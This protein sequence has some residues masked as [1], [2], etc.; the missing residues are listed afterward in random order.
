[1]FWSRSTSDSL[2]TSDAEAGL[3][4]SPRSHSYTRRSRSRSRRRQSRPQTPTAIDMADDEPMARPLPMP[5]T[6]PSPGGAASSSGSKSRKKPKKSARI[7]EEPRPTLRVHWARFK[8]HMGTGTAPSTSSAIGGDESTTA[9]ESAWFRA[10]GGVAFDDE[11]GE[12]DEVVVDR[13]WL[14]EMKSTVVSPSEFPD[15]P[16]KSSH[17]PATTT[18]HDSQTFR[19]TGAVLLPYMVLRYR[20]WPLV[21]DFFH[22]KFF[23]EKSEMHYRKENWFM[24]KVRPADM[25][26]VEGV[27]HFGSLWQSGVPYFS[28]STGWAMGVLCLLFCA[29][30]SFQVLATAFAPRPLPLADKIFFYAVSPLFTFPVF[31]MVSARMSIVGRAAC[32]LLVQVIYNWPRDRPNAYQLFLSCS[33]WQWPFYNILFMFLCGF[34]PGQHS[35]F[36]CG[37]KDFIGIF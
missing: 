1:M 28:L 35:H 23:D 16:D 6:T 30:I 10:R 2:D 3:P 11:Q 4:N 27:S 33:V 13:E 29:Q 21:L 24:K 22:L 25:L 32:S 34:Y 15:G 20:I 12:L 18:D 8:R 31:F 14:H 17:H 37:N 9:G 36:T 26:S 19:G 5:V 7:E